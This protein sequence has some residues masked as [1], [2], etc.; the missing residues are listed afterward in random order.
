MAKKGIMNKA[1]G[2]MKSHLCCTY[3]FN[4]SVCLTGN[5]TGEIIQWDGHELI[6]VHKAHSSAAV[7]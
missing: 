2:D 5:Q 3:A 1:R 6:K 4:S 7:W